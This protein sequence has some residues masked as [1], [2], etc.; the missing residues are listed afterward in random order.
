MTLIL[1]ET[2]YRELYQASVNTS[3]LGLISSAKE[4]ETKR[5]LPA[6]LGCGHTRCLELSPGIWLDLIDKEFNQPW[7]LKVPIHEHLVQCTIMLKGVV[8]Y[9]DT[10][11]T[12]GKGKS[13]LSG[14]GLS[15][16][17][18]ARYGR[19]DHLQGVNIHLTPDALWPFL[20]EQSPTLQQLLLKTNDW[21]TAWFPQ[22]TPAMQLVAEQMMQCPFQGTTR[23]LYL[24]AK[25]FELLALQ[26]SAV[27]ENEG[28]TAPSPPLKSSTID[29]IY[30]ARDILTAHLENPP[31]LTELA[32]QIGVSDRTLRRGFRHLF[33][34]TVIGY[35][36]QQRMIQAKELLQQSNHTV[37]EVA[38][39]VGYAHLGHFAA[40]FR[41][42]FGVSP[43]EWME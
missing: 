19:F 15:P 17:Y 21:K 38:N 24:Q 32:Q 3:H 23:R 20:A 29:K 40:A 42:Q 22:V 4:A 30:Q 28:K 9:D 11:P 39:K 25:V 6:M 43:K 1:S 12:L 2:D 34:T 8:D 33:G 16:G 14:S 27:M 35:L 18:T 5:D 37:A 10:Y 7:A 36:T 13:Y 31:L 26:L 41:R